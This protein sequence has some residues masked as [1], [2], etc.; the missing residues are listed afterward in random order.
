M[1]AACAKGV[2]AWP[3][4]PQGLSGQ[5]DTEK[6]LQQRAELILRRDRPRFLALRRYTHELVFRDGNV[7]FFLSLIHI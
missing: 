7:A 5:H 4:R 6:F 1:S 2:G 3:R